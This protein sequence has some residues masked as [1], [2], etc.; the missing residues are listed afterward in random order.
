MNGGSNKSPMNREQFNFSSLLSPSRIRSLFCVYTAYFSHSLFWA[1]EYLNGTEPIYDTHFTY[2]TRFGSS[3]FTQTI[4]QKFRS[5][6]SLAHSWSTQWK[7]KM[8]TEWMNERSEQANEMDSLFHFP[9]LQW[10]NIIDLYLCHHPKIFVALCMREHECGGHCFFPLLFCSFSFQRTTI[11]YAVERG[12][13]FHAL[14][15]LVSRTDTGSV[16]NINQFA[17]R[18]VWMTNSRAEHKHMQCHASI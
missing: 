11:K 16:P 9:H 4:N 13:F 6:L 5:F 10:M 3:I 14:F 17:F 12:T 8:P 1:F 7:N 15:S 2:E 18:S